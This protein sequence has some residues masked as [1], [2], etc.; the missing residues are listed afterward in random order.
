MWE[1]ALL[2]T[3]GWKL[4]ATEVVGY[5]QL[6][7]TLLE[8]LD[9]ACAKRAAASIAKD[10]NG[11]IGADNAELCAPDH[12]VPRDDPQPNSAVLSND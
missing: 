4:L 10:S 6:V 2:D 5:R 1:T 9:G 7:Q 11:F 8:S 3:L 12:V